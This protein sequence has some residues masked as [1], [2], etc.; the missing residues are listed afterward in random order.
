MNMRMFRATITLIGGLLVMAAFASLASPQVSAAPLAALTET[1]EPPTA[2]PVPPTATPVPPTA[3]AATATALPTEVPPAPTQTPFPEE[4]V[5]DD[6]EEPT[7]TPISLVSTVIPPSPTMTAQPSETAAPTM[8]AAPSPT[9]QPLPA[10]LPKTGDPA[11][12]GL[13]TALL[14][15]GLALIALGAGVRQR[16]A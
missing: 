2:T 14:L 3:I 10:S 11:S 9:A 4:E 6:N 5:D 8:T 13:S 7:A 1:A 16:R 15:I 12:G